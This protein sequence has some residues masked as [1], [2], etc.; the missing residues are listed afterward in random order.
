MAR[1][2]YLLGVAPEELKR[3]P[4]SEK[5][6]QTP[7]GKWENF[8]YHYK[9]LTIG[10]G[11]AVVILTLL[12]VQ[13]FTRVEPDYMICMVTTQ[14][15]GI[16]S[17]KRLEE[18]LAAYAKDRNGDGK[19]KVEVRCLN[20]SPGD[21]DLANPAA[22]TNQQAAMGHILVRDVDLWAV[23]PSFYTGTLRSAFD[24]DESAFFLPLDI[25]ADGISD[26]G[27]YWNWE[28]LTI[29]DTD[30]GLWSMPDTL[31]WGVRVLSDDAPEE[32]KTQVADMHALL[33]SFAEDQPK[34]E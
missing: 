14:E 29:L 18:I 25:T 34:K 22:V 8:W 17:D 26:D 2:R 21:G 20:V 27:K 12:L 1:E 16:D 15:V 31:Y 6:P 7:R 4:T 24:G 11:I 19:I 5:A 28:G 13:T 33:K 30:E 32:L 23:A 9:G 3:N 10:I